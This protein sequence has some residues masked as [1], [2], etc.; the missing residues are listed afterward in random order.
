MNI[1]FTKNPTNPNTTNPN[2]VCAK[3]FANSAKQ[4]LIGERKVSKDAATSDVRF[5][6]CTF[7]I[8]LCTPLNEAHAVL[9]ESAERLCDII[10]PGILHFEQY[11]SAAGQKPEVKSAVLSGS[12]LI[13]QLQAELTMQGAPHNTTGM[14]DWQRWLFVFA[15]PLFYMALRWYVRQPSVARRTFQDLHQCTVF[16]TAVSQRLPPSA[17][18][19][20]YP[21]SGTAA[22]SLVAIRR[23]PWCCVRTCTML[24]PGLAYGI[25]ISVQVVS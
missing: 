7:L 24:I 1:N 3:I 20:P 14:T 5:I 17:P 13:S 15:G 22:S 4:P 21:P 25:I 11:V 23:A 6:S 18:R 8:W 16:A 12:A 2:A 19:E 10:E 9:D